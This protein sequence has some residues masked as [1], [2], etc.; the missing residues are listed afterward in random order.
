M[1]KRCFMCNGMSDFRLH[2]S[3]VTADPCCPANIL[4]FYIFHGG[5][6]DDNLVSFFIYFAELY[7]QYIPVHVQHIL[8]LILLFVFPHMPFP[9]TQ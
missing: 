6:C 9:Q 8:L 7:V 2:K 4:Y 5:F 3:P 1:F